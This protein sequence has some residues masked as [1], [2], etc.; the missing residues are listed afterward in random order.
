M[1]LSQAP[2]VIIELHYGREFQP[3]ELEAERRVWET[4]GCFEVRSVARDYRDAMRAAEEPFK[5]GN[6]WRVRRFPELPRRT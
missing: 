3:G 1:V 6:K 5:L 4:L 2:E